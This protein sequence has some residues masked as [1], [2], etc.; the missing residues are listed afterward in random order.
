VR[1]TG[2]AGSLDRPSR[3][4][5]SARRRCRRRRGHWRRI[6]AGHGDAARRDRDYDQCGR[7]DAAQGRATAATTGKHGT[8]HRPLES[9]SGHDGEQR[10]QLPALR[11]HRLAER[12]T[13]R[14]VIDVPPQG[15]AP[16]LGAARARQLLADVGAGRVARH[17]VSGQRGAGLEDERLHLLA[18]AVED[19]GDL[20]VGNIAEL[21][22]HECGSLGSGK[23]GEAG[24]HRAQ[25]LAQRDIGHESIG[26]TLRERGGR[27]LAPRAQQ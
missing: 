24:E 23:A 5:W 11:P 15:R 20:V 9:E 13:S 26:P 27:Q 19:A 18:S 22:Q 21:G 25:L 14:A 7:R 1:G 8:E 3:E 6:V 12:F 10:P 4:R 2:P 16:Q 17:A